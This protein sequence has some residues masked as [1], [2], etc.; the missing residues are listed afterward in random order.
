MSNPNAVIIP[1][2]P[3]R[4]ELYLAPSPT[5]YSIEVTFRGGVACLGGD[6]IHYLTPNNALDLAKALIQKAQ[7]T[8][9]VAQ[10]RRQEAQEALSS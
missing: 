2:S 10:E 7:E 5:G 3:I 8:G 1:L 4:G 9:K 6:H